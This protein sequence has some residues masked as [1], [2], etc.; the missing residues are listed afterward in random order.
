MKDLTWLK[1]ELIAHRGLY[2]TDQVVPE[3]SLLAFK[4][5]L[6]KDYAI[7]CDINML[8]DG[9]VVVFH[10]YDLNRVLNDPR[11]IDDLDYLEIKKMK[12][13][14]TNETIP[15]LNQLLNLVKGRKPILIELKPHGNVKELCHKTMDILKSYNGQYALFSFH[16]KVVS[17]LKK[18]Y[19]HVIRGQ[20]AEYFTQQKEMSKL[21]KYLMKT[22]FFNRFTKPDFISYGIHDLPNKYVD[23]YK[24]KGLT[25]ISYQARS[26]KA[27]DHVKSYYDNVVFEHFEPKK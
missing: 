16:P 13:F 18:H 17:V 23:K 5:A 2:T 20:I 27:F 12:L 22:M 10:D 7:E 19:P 4:R 15:T 14:G 1:T 26:Q 9:T 11:H 21:Q 25:I 8:K 24:R 3:N 6:E